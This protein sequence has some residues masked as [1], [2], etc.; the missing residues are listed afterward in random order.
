[1][2]LYTVA[3]WSTGPDGVCKFRVASQL[4]RAGVLAKNG[5]TAVTLHALPRA[6]TKEAAEVYLLGSEGKIP[7]VAES[8]V[9]EVGG[10]R[11]YVPKDVRVKNAIKLTAGEKR[12]LQAEFSK[13]LTQAWME[14]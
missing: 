12:S 8:A 6:M 9:I 11:S 14:N 7:P 3:G 2:T 13:T 5:H 1:M 4:S 10:R